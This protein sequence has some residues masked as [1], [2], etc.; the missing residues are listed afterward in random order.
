MTNKLAAAYGEIGKRL[1]IPVFHAGLAFYEI[2]TENS[3]IELYN[4]DLSHPSYAGSY[5]A[6]ATLYAGIFGDVPENFDGELSPSDASLLRKTA[7]KHAIS[8]SQQCFL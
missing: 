4:P 8:S 1:Q 7:K 2:Y 6:A 3:G 5:L